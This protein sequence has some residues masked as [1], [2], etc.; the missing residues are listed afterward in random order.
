MHFC[1]GEACLARFRTDSPPMLSGDPP[2][3]RRTADCHESNHR[4][5]MF[6][7]RHWPIHG[8]HGT[9]ASPSMIVAFPTSIHH[10]PMTGDPPG[11][12]YEFTYKHHRTSNFN[13]LFAFLYGAR[14]AS[15]VFVPIH[16]QRCRATHRVA[17]YDSYFKTW[18]HYRQK[19]HL[20]IPCLGCRSALRSFSGYGE[21]IEHRE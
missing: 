4:T 10:R 12:P 1:R 6:H 15:P 9:G 20:S 14:H 2:G 19:G 21:S 13:E 7:C 8:T 11:R 17:P 3:P 5:N 18:H 16:H